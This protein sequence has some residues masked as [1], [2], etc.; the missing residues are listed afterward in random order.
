MRRVWESWLVLCGALIAHAGLSS[1]AVVD[2][3][4]LANPSYAMGVAAVI[5]AVRQ[6]TNASVRF[7]IGF[8]GDSTVLMQYFACVGV[9]TSDVTVRLSSD[10]IDGPTLESL[11][12]HA[13]A[14]RLHS[15]S[16][17]A[18]F[19]LAE[20]FSEVDVAW[21]IDSDALPLDDLVAPMAEFVQSGAAIRPV[22]S[23]DSV[24]PTI[25]PSLDPAVSELYKKKYGRDIVLNAPSWN[26]GVWL[27]SLEKWRSRMLSEEALF[28][29]KER[30]SFAGPAVLWKLATQPLMYILFNEDL[31]SAHGFLPHRWNCEVRH[32][33]ERAVNSTTD[34]LRTFVV[35][36]HES[37]ETTCSVVHWNGG[38][39]PWH[40]RAFE[41]HLWLRYLPKFG[42]PRCSAILRR[43]ATRVSHAT[44]N[45]TAARASPGGKPGLRPVSQAQPEAGMRRSQRVKLKKNATT[46]VTP[47]IA[48][49][50][51]TPGA[52][53]SAAT[54]HANTSEVE[55][56]D[57]GSVITSATRSAT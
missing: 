42:D 26:A 55:R 40:R 44:A 9:A 22:L 38:N 34:A 3:I 49:P 10:S 35:K 53:P 25:E 37:R 28:W 41:H 46:V 24:K 47:A 12:V 50:T 30:I 14:K 6:H 8:D 32:L 15:V 18:R 11:P 52:G 36:G 51:V 5:N 1:P 19:K 23:W 4:L 57:A 16:N 45:G 20:L 2:V 39:K 27:A 29:M 56:V 31:P 17:F 33:R 43:K 13:G 21:Y 54:L 48:S 7:W